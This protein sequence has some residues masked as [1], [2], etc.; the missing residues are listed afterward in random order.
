MPSL[1]G[2][3]VSF[4]LHRAATFLRRRRESGREVLWEIFRWHAP[5][6]FAQG[7]LCRYSRAIRAVSSVVEH[8]VYTDSRVIFPNYPDLIR[9]AQR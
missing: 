8:L 7:R 3:A 5:F 4:P 6:D 2:E 1:V 9:R